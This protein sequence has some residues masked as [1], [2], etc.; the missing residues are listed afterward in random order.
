MAGRA[1][2]DWLR[3]PGV[4][5]VLV[6]LV[7]PNVAFVALSLAGISVPPRSLPIIL[8]LLA[9]ISIRFLPGWA[10]VAAFIAAFSFDVMF[11]ATQLFGLTLTEAVFALR[12]INELD[13]LSSK[14][15][16]VLILLLGGIF[17][18][19]SYLLLKQGATLRRARATIM[20]CL[21]IVALP[22]DLWLNTPRD[23][24][25]WLKLG[26]DLPF[27]S[28]IGNSG[29][30][31]LVE[32]PN[33]RHMLVVIVEAMGH[34]AD[35]KMQGLLEQAI[36]AGG[37]EQ[38]YTVTSGTNGFIGGTTSAEMRE[39]CQTRDSY[40]D[41]LDR[42]RPD[43]LPF[44]MSAA[45]YTTGGY[46]G[47]SGEMF[48]RS[49][50]WPHIGFTQR[51]FGEDL[52][53]PGDKLCGDVFVGICDPKLVRD[54]AAQ[55]KAATSPQFNYLLTFNTHVP[56]IVDQGYHHLDCSRRGSVVPEREVCIM[57]DA[58]IELLETIAK[59]FAAAD[60]PPT[61]ILIVGDHAPPLW[62]RK[63]RDLFT[64]RQVSWFRLSPKG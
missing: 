35:P 1:M 50:W 41:N 47:F 60:V 13:I 40:L 53:Q 20:L 12:F 3:R 54:L 43:C 5:L 4:L 26:Q 31:K 19:I 49:K 32:Q 38:R 56:V 55:F 63:A 36:R 27:D 14:L 23:S 62:Y 42:P 6:G 7:L 37:V 57:T 16:I 10:V 52:M 30:I 48:E 44:K 18:L 9:A 25:V 64:P 61:E 2:I 39:F 45:G 59:A 34:F 58:W 46:H 33:G 22:V 51:H 29:F 17:A 21:G 11:C 8:Y 15:Y 24:T 28:A